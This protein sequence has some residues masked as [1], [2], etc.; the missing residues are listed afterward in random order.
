MTLS[1]SIPCGPNKTSI[2]HT[3]KLLLG[4]AWVHHQR[5]WYPTVPV[6][7]WDFVRLSS[8]QWPQHPAPVAFDGSGVLICSQSQRR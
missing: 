6:S 3:H 5:N 4:N 2:I 7:Q 8:S 1:T